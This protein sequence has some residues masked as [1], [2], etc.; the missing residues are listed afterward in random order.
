MWVGGRKLASIGIGVR[1]GVAYHGVALNVSTDL[2]YFGHIVPCRTS[3][4]AVTSLAEIL[5][6][7]PPLSAVGGAFAECLAIELGCDIAEPE[8]QV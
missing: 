2:S 3:G 4:L 1:R 8:E 5:G 7:A 6:T